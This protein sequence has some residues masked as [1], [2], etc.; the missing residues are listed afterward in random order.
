MGELE[1]SPCSDCQVGGAAGPFLAGTDL[2]QGASVAGDPS[3]WN[4]GVTSPVEAAN[5][6]LALSSRLARLPRR[7]LSH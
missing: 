7:G 5:G 4:S 6:S 1:V 3:S 2:A